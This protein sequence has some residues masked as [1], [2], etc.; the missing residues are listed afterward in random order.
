MSVKM[1]TAIHAGKH[2]V[3]M[4]LSEIAHPNLIRLMQ[5][6]G[7]E[8]V[9]VDCEHGYFDYSQVAA[10]AAVAS[11]IDFPMIVR[12]PGLSRECV[13]KYL[14]A[15]VDGVWVPMLETAEQA[16]E[17]VRLGKYAPLGQ[18]GISTMRPHSN[19]AP[20]KL[21]EYTKK[22]N[23]RTMLFAQIETRKGAENAEEIAAVKGLDGIFI[24]PNDLA[25]DLGCTGDFNTP[26]MEETIA[27]I[28]SAAKAHGMPCGIV[29]SN[30]EFLKKWAAR[31]MTMFSC[32]SEL[33]LLKKGIQSMLSCVGLT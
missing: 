8:F 19:Y 22:A 2:T 3:G 29:A 30:P 21:T 28:L 16:R 6:A 31:G 12:M 7:A 4:F 26:V 1:K 20:G 32:D 24:G 33:G 17:L 25:C 27:H 9:V 15:G 23:D 5:A 10:I 14:D 18:R 11:G 13:Q